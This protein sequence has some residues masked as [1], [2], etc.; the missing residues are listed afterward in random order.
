MAYLHT[1]VCCKCHKAAQEMCGA[2]KIKVVCSACEQ[3]EDDKARRRHFK[4][5]DGLTLEER[6]RRLEEAAYD[7]HNETDIRDMRF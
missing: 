7:K 4:G 2:G 1:F 3:K 6:V 5:L